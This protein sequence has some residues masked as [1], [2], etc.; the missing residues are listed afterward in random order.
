LLRFIRK[1]VQ[2]IVVAFVTASLTAGVPAVASTIVDYARNAGKVDGFR[3][4]GPTSDASRRSRVLVATGRTGYLPSDII[5]K[6]PNSNLLDGADSSAFY[7]TT[8]TVA[9][10]THAVDADTLGGLAASAYSTRR[11]DSGMCTTQNGNQAGTC[12]FNFTFTSAPIVVI[13]PVNDARACFCNT[14]WGPYVYNISTTG[15]SLD[16]TSYVNTFEWVAVGS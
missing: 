8:D 5:R 11:I 14:A 12:S 3:A 16:P 13:T 2:V 7:K 6:A 4:V 9:E 1:N 15:F 10:A